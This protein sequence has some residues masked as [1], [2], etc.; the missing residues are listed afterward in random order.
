MNIQPEAQLNL[1]ELELETQ[2]RYQFTRLLGHGAYGIVVAGIDKTTGQEV[3]IK[4]VERIFDSLLDAKRIMREI[5][6]LS[7]MNHENITNL[8]DVSSNPDFSQ[9]KAIIVV[10]DLMETDMRRVI[11]QNPQL[12][13]EHHRYFLY[14]IL[15]GLKYIHSANVLHR[16]LKPSNLLLNSDCDLKICDFGLARVLDPAEGIDLSEY[17][18]TRWYR[19]PEVLLCYDKYGPAIDIWSVGCILAELIL[20]RPLFPGQSTIDQLNLIVD[21]LGTPSEDDLVDC[22][23]IKARAYMDG[24]PRKEKADMNQIFNGADPQEVDMIEKMLTWNPNN[25]MTVDQ[26][27]DHPFVENLHDP[28]DEPVTYPFE[29][30]EFESPNLTMEEV[31]DL[32]WKEILKFHPEFVH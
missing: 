11:M 23:N 5:R 7:H 3:A 21:V 17:V 10:V 15:R 26:A 30:F 6:I 32:M 12:M 1:A 28:F 19:A 22:T 2:G 4:R 14:Q 8:I 20:R 25:R 29:D 24:L 31:K 16:D 13:P 27:L 18:E 9:F